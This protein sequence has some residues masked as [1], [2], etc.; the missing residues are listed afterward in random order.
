MPEGPPI[1]VKRYYGKYRGEVTSNLDLD[2]TMATLHR[3]QVSVPD[4]F[5]AGQ[6]VWALPCMPYSGEGVGFY[7]KP[8]VGASVWVEFEGGNPNNPIWTGN[9]WDEAEFLTPYELNFL[10]PAMVKIIQTASTTFVLNDTDELGGVTLKV[11]DPAVLIPVSMTFSSL[12]VKIETG[13]CS[14]SMVP[15]EGIT[16]QVGEVVISMTPEGINMTGP[17]ITA[18]AEADINL[19]AGGAIEAEA[20]GDLSLAAGGAA[21]LNAGADVEIAAGAAI[22]INAG[23]DVEIAAGGAAE[24]NAGA[25]VEIAAGA[26]IEI[27]AGLNLEMAAGLAVELNAGVDVEIAAAAGIQLTAVGDIAI[28]A[29]SIMETGLVEVNGLLLIDGQVPLVI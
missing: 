12:G 5:P 17:A 29:V 2:P 8:P 16:L 4:V 10:D 19:S 6:E 14:L 3:I 25:D 1:G 18:E 28:T 7:M 20:G 13:I 9:F 11:T 21:E 15:E 26:A 22:E 24:L 23:A 27:N